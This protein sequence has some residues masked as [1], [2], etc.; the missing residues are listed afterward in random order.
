MAAELERVLATLDDFSAEELGAKVKEYGNTAPYTKNLLSDPYLFNLMFPSSIGPY[1]LMPRWDAEI[2]SSY[3]WI[4]CFGIADRS[5]YD[6]K[7]HS[8]FF[9]GGG[10]VGDGLPMR[11]ACGCTERTSAKIRLR[12]A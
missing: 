10:H 4:E 9:S 12:K 1:G 5:T 8:H 3:G 6:L 7:A 2:E 11:D